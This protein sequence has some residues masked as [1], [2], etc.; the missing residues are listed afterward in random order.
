MH[1]AA[2]FGWI[3]HRRFV[4]ANHAFRYRI[5]MLLLD[6]DEAPTL[7]RQRWLWSWNAPNIASVQRRDHLAD[8]PDD[9]ATAARDCIAEQT[10]VRPQGPI[11][12]LAQ[13]RYFGYCINPISL[14]LVHSPDRSRLEWLIAEVHN[15]PWDERHPY[16]LAAPAQQSH[17]L[18]VDFGKQ[19][20]VSP[21]FDMQMQYRLRLRYQPGQKLALSIDNYRDD[22]RLFAANLHLALQPADQRGLAKLLTA[23]PAMTAKVAVG[24][25]FQALRLKLKGVPYVP[26]PKHLQ[27]SRSAS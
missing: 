5:S 11:S 20:H 8:G 1:S 10:G 3:N 2:G 18:T 25:Y 19:L 13:P 26:H 27:T 21:F 16:V 6:L 14:F 23:T 17:G 4:S 24:I 9:L 22:E 15:T 7:F 12:L